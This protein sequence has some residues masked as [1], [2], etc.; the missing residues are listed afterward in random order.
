MACPRGKATPDAHTRIRLFSDSGGH[1]QK[2]DCLAD[3]FL[4][5]GN[6]N[7]HIAEMA[8]VFSASNEGP[9]ADATLSREE[10]G[11]YENLILLCVKCHTIIDKAPDEFPDRLLA[12][13]KRSHKQRIDEAFGVLTYTTRRE[14][15]VAIE[16]LLEENHYVFNKYGPETDE[17]Y[18]PESD[19]PLLWKQ[20]I[21]TKLLPNNRRLLRLLDRNRRHLRPDEF[22]LLEA[23]RQHVDDFEKKHLEPDLPSGSRFP[24]EL[25]GI[26]YDD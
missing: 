3:L 7:I 24:A 4:E 23:F 6:T 13:W 11:A 18:N 12:E 22:K 17:R 25:E 10:R 16:P 9:R 21:L 15:R 8:H 1:C 20:K 5:I 19:M 26:L 2:P 14:A